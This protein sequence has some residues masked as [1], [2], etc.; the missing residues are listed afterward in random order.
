VYRLLKQ[1]DELKGGV[2]GERRRRWEGF[3]GQE[4]WKDVGATIGPRSWVVRG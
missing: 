1:G 2:C 3:G 4:D